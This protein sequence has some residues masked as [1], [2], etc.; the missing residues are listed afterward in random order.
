[1]KTVNKRGFS[2]LEVLVSLAVLGIAIV[3]LGSTLPFGMTATQKITASTQAVFLAQARMEELAST[4]YG[5]LVTEEINEQSL[6]NIDPDFKKF[7]R[8]TKIDY[9]DQ[10]LNIIEEDEGLKKIEVIVSWRDPLRKT[11][12]QTTLTSLRA[13]F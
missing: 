13:D 3:F 1:M 4:P 8:E 9:L 2:I 7:S 10:D 6:E 11:V 12:T 5:G